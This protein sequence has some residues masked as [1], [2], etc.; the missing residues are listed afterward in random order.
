M[1]A[2][3]TSTSLGSTSA[4]S[5][6]DDNA[7]IPVIAASRRNSVRLD[8]GRAVSLR[9]D[10]AR[11][12]QVRQGKVWITR[13]ATVRRATEDVVL[14]CGEAMRLSAGDRI[15]LEPWDAN[16]A[17]YTWDIASAAA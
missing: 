10:C 1:S 7:T 3:F 5:A 11:V 17:T 4:R 13:D 2:A 8:A 9:A 14:G 15:V 16:G 12:L 6:T